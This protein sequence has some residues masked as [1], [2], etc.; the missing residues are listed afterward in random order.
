MV[1]AE[2]RTPVPS[3]PRVAPADAGPDAGTVGQAVPI[4][5]PETPP[6]FLR[7]R[8]GIT[9]GVLV[10]ELIQP[11]LGSGARLIARAVLRGPP[12]VAMAGALRP[13]AL[14]NAVLATPALVTSERA[15]QMADGPSSAIAET[16]RVA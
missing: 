6:P 11:R 15:H 5:K 13:P 12:V 4:P 9:P 10:P 16:V 3:K 2:L 14:L 1:L 7:L 8:V